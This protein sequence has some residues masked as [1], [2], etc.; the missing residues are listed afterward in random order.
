MHHRQNKRKSSPLN[1]NI[2][3]RPQIPFTIESFNKVNNA[4]NKDDCFNSIPR[5]SNPNL[6]RAIP[7]ETK[8]TENKLYNNKDMKKEFLS[9][10]YKNY[11]LKKRLSSHNIKC[12]SNIKSKEKNGTR[13]SFFDST[14]ENSLKIQTLRQINNVINQ[15]M[16]NSKLEKVQEE[17]NNLENTEVSKII[18]D[19]PQSKIEKTKYSRLSKTNL[20]SIFNESNLYNLNNSELNKLSKFTTRIENLALI[21]DDRLQKKYRKLYLSRNLYDSLDDEEI[22]DVEKIYLLYISPNSLTVY[23]LDFFVLISSFVELY[24]LPI[25]ISLHI[26]SNS[27]YSNLISSFIFYIIDFIYIIDLITGFFRAYY[28][29]EEV[30][31][32]KKADLC[33]NYLTGWFFPD[34]IEA[35]PIFT[36]LDRNL[37]KSIKNLSDSR[38][39]HIQDFGINN[40]FFALTILKSFKIFK[41]FSFNRLFNK[42]YKYLDKFLFFYE[43]KGLIFSILLVFS[44]LHLFTCFFIF[45]GRNEFQGWIFQNNLQDKSYIDLYIASLYY[46]MAT[47]TTVGYGDITANVSLEKIYGTFILILG[48]FTYSWILTNISNYIKK[49]NEKYIDFEEKMKVLTEI[50]IEYPNLNNDLYDRIRRYL[51]YNKSGYNNNIKFI[52]ESLPSSLQNNLII[53]IYKPIIMNF[54]FFKSF[55]NSNFFVKI[56]TSLKPILSMKND[57]LIQEGDIIEDIIFIKKG[58][59]TLEII[60]DLNDPKNSIK[61]HLETT[62]KSCFNNISN[63]KLTELINHNTLTPMYQ[64]ELNKPI[65]YNKNK[66]EIKIIDLRRNEHFGDILMILNEKSPVAVKVKSKKAELFF[67]QKTEAT[68]ISNR[69]SNIWKRIVNRS[70][71]NMKQIKYLIR[72][73]LFLFIEAN[74]I[75]MDEDFKEKYLS[76]ENYKSVVN[77][78]KKIKKHK[79]PRSLIQLS[80]SARFEDQSTSIRTKKNKIKEHNNSKNDLECFSKINNKKKSRKVFFK[81]DIND[82]EDNLKTEIKENSNVNAANDVINLFNKELAKSSKSKPINHFNISIYA[83]N[84]HFPLNQINIENQNSNIFQI[85]KEE[86]ISEGHKNDSY[87]LNQVNNE[88]SFSK[89][90]NINFKDNDILMNNSDENSNIIFLNSKLDKNNNDK[91]ISDNNSSYIIKI[92]DKNEF[93]KKQKKEKAEIKTNDNISIK[94][95]SSDKSK[96]NKNNK[97]E[98]IKIIKMLK[99]SN[100]NT[101]QS[102]SFSIKSIYENFNEISQYKL[103][104]SPDLREKAK[105]FILEQIEED[106][107]KLILNKKTEINSKLLHIKNNINFNS[108]I[109]LSRR[110]SEIYD[111][112]NLSN[113]NIMRKMELIKRSSIQLDESKIESKIIPKKSNRKIR[114][115]A[116]TPKILKEDKSERYF[117]AINKNRSLFKKKQGRRHESSRD[118]TFYN[119]IIRKRSIKNERTDISE[120]VQ[121]NSEINYVRLIS[122]NI[123]NNQQNLNNPEEYFQGF[124]KDII[125][126]KKYDN[127]NIT[128]SKVKF[129]KRGTLGY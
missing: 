15:T 48:T 71:H 93:D 41:T 43:W 87:Y 98:D 38:S 6:V 115:Y 10:K 77:S 17:L 70:L 9:A 68:E 74:N 121:K 65:I 128:T 52:L 14:S 117:S 11:S 19:L 94:S 118:H 84:L 8:L 90:T 105:K 88:I 72:K 122:K 46:Q 83:Q 67:L 27:I 42:I 16:I 116:R 111:K 69:Y 104:K 82:K 124:F 40:K 100:L 63:Q 5:R 3:K 58:V 103:D 112:S 44:S 37:Q 125:S 35:V 66:K 123:E 30:L 102:T 23:I 78:N 92:L 59:L 64:P 80:N 114:R 54:Q 89:D 12:K 22:P 51:N 120:K 110:S 60:V 24:Y 34:L 109:S 53:E 75:Q 55:E 49:N 99:F 113:K 76:K 61:S 1:K 119:Q 85:K 25:Y 79:S 47:L 39:Y 107:N 21:P 45:I 28:N 18:N 86:N 7:N 2:F 108:K 26:T 73:K 31:I 127:V 56:V 129:K 50:K 33:I 36:F 29:F 106:K 57:I 126:K 32:K 91:N 4:F 96:L 95:V 13:N 97:S 20:E 101:S 81:S 62:G